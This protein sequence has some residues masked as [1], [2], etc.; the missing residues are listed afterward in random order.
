MDTT[1]PRIELITA[2]G[3]KIV[4]RLGNPYPTYHTLAARKSGLKNKAM[5]RG[6]SEYEIVAYLPSRMNEMPV[7]AFNNKPK[8][9]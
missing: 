7:E 6:Y 1:E 2:T 5:K 3:E 4:T 8:E 9:P